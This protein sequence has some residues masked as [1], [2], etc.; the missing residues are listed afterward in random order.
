MIS[1]QVGL[2][3]RGVIYAIDALC[4]DR[5]ISF[6]RNYYQIIINLRRLIIERE[7]FRKEKTGRMVPW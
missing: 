7:K 6:T 5:D 4:N 1:G 3:S 2:V